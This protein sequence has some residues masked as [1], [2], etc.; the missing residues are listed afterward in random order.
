VC[1]AHAGWDAAWRWNRDLVVVQPGWRWNE[2]EGLGSLGGDSVCSESR[3]EAAAERGTLAMLPLACCAV[4]ARG[5]HG[6]WQAGIVRC[7][8][9]PRRMHEA[10]CPP[11]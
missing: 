7:L 2:R 6:P 3:G 9:C 4:W 10:C 5:Q 8:D 11:Q 1:K